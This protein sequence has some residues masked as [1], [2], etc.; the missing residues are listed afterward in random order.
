MLGIIFSCYCLLL[1]CSPARNTCMHVCVHTRVHTLLLPKHPP[2]LL[3]EASWGNSPAPVP[4]WLTMLF[5]SQDIVSLTLPSFARVSS[6]PSSAQNLTPVR[7]RARVPRIP[8]YPGWNVS[9]LLC[10]VG[11]TVPSLLVSQL[12]RGLLPLG[13]C[14]C[15][16][17]PLARSS[18]GNP[19]FLQVSAPTPDSHEVSC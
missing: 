6:H 14:D 12:P 9:P 19:P 11:I 5:L 1:S 8:W 15:C 3:W 2:I 16:F 18:P 17:L 10:C 13:H 4:L 7:V